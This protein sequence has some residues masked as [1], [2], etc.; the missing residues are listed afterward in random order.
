M[1]PM[2]AEDWIE[3]KQKF[4][5]IAQPK[6]DG[7]R[8]LNMHGALSRRSLRPFNNMHT[9]RF[10]SHPSLAGLDGEMC[11]ADERDPAL[12]RLTTSALNS[13]DGAPFTL[14]WL[15]DYITVDTWILPYSERYAMLHA[16]ILYL[17]D[18]LPA[19]SAAS[20]LRLIPSV[21]VKGPMELADYE[22]KWLD[23]GYEGVILRKPDGAYKQGRSTP[24]EG[25]LLRIKRF[26]EEDAVVKRII[27]GQTNNNAATI[28][29][30]GNTERSTHAENMVPNGMVGAMECTDV[31][32]GEDITVAAGC[33]TH[34][35]RKRYFENPDDL[36]LKTIK[37]K[38]FPKGVKDKPRFPTF[39]SLRMEAD[40]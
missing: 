3:A 30:L 34:D 39:Q 28:N 40:K 23:E 16:R 9:T 5:V 10:Y 19:A 29:A 36:L 35:E 1:K 22:A 37:Y 38:R 15:F 13:K 7:V 32:T 6:I 25:G 24:R 12:C 27:E 33:M 18:T 20:R 14:W 8:A 4:P 17:Q 11:A 31:K 21:L 26:I 2:L